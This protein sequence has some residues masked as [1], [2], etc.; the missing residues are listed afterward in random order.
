[1]Q[2]FQ[3]LTIIIS[4]ITVGMTI[5]IKITEA[6]CD[7]MLQWLRDQGWLHLPGICEE[8]QDDDEDFK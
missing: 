2:L 4:S 7:K 8:C 1:M 6:K 5:G 3:I